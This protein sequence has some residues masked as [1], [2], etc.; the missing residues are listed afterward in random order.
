MKYSA[1]LIEVIGGL[2]SI[3]GAIVLR[4]PQVRV[5]C[6][7]TED[8]AI[9]LWSLTTGSDELQQGHLLLQLFCDP[10]ADEASRA[11]HKQFVVIGA[12]RTYHISFFYSFL[13]ILFY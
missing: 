5:L 6:H 7:L 8:I 4:K 2:L 13:I 3:L 12:G 10:L 11:R 9:A 1:T